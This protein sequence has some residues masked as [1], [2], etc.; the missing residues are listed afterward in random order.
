MHLL[1][2]EIIQARPTGIR[3][4]SQC[5]EP[6][7]HTSLLIFA[8]FL[9]LYMSRTS[10]S[11]LKARAQLFKTNDVASLKRDVKPAFAATCMHGPH[12]VFDTGHCTVIHCDGGG[13]SLVDQ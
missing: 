9:H 8:P 1:S 3:A 13:V 2:C 10:P 7:K 11:S 4:L 12:S 5:R 6:R